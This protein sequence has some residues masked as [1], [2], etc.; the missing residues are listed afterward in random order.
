MKGFIRENQMFSLC[1]LN[2]GLCPMFIGKY[3]GGCGNGNQ[4]CKIARCSLE[5]GAPEYCYECECYPCEKYEHVDE[6]DSFITHRRQKADLEK[7][8]RTGIATYNAE[9][10]EKVQ[11]LQDLLDNLKKIDPV[12]FE[13][14]VIDLMEKM[15]YGVGSMTKLSHDGGIDG[16]INEDELGLGK[17]YLQAKRYS[18][19][20]KSR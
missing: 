4:S 2:C 11:I 1:G 19:N 16:I 14:I 18:E 7:A 8:K 15:N 5:H 13:R 12:R 10:S 9:Q 3:C 17:I 20:N 6:F